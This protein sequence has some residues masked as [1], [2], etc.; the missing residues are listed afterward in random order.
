MYKQ[1]FFQCVRRLRAWRWLIGIGMA[2]LLVS[3]TT[4]TA[5]AIVNQLG[6]L[7]RVNEV[8]DPALPEHAN[9]FDVR[10]EDFE[11][12]FEIG[13]EFFDTTFNA[14]DGVGANVGNGQRF[15][16]IPRA[17]LRGAGQWFNH[18]PAR[19]TGPN[20]SAC[21]E[22]HVEPGD[23][24]GP[25]AANVH[26]DPRRGGVLSQFIERN[27]P[28]LFGMGGVQVLAEEMTEELQAIR[29]AAQQAACTSGS[30]RRDLIAKGLRFGVIVA[31][32]TGTN[33]CRVTFDT[34]A[35]VG[36][37]TDLVVR[38]FQWKGVNTTVRDFSRGASH[39]ELGLTPNE[40]LANPNADGDGDGIA[41][42]A[43]VGDMTALA[44][45]LA[46]QPRP[47]TLQEL[48]SLGLIDP[49]SFDS[50]AVDRGR[51][52]FN[53]L[54]CDFCH[55][56]QM[57]INDPVFFEPS[58][59]PNFRDATFPGGANPIAAGLDPA[60][61][62]SFDLTTDMPDNPV[63]TPNGTTLGNFKRDSQ[64]RAIVELYG[65]LKR[66]NMGPRLN[67]PVDEVGTGAGTFLTENLWGVG[68]TAPYL[69]DGRATTIGEAILMHGG[70]AQPSRDAFARLGA[71]DRE[72]VLAYLENLVL[73]KIPE[74]E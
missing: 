35:V 57:V 22:C 25:A 50:A 67:E 28:H 59:N 49:S 23:G 12:V 33:P 52:V 18:L 65:D 66:H 4:V 45:Y 11:E 2:I 63:M 71:Q 24:S 9:Q 37:A 74:E 31:N 15:T 13:D 38:P 47:T 43:T 61:A 53:Q 20:A 64:G 60:F 62:N 26:R 16:R 73:F 6:E 39:G 40:L 36:V 55:T 54:R 41:N 44:V 7:Q 8:H 69:H 29:A 5:L 1:R 21:T 46:A 10:A 42:E 51:Q 70:E 32:R 72:A 17:D 19:A 56:P 30:A 34:T 68:S 48:A 58:Q 27:T 14:L 3:S